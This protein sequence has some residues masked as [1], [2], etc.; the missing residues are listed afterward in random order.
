MTAYVLV[1]LG[2][3][4]AIIGVMIV[5]FLRADSRIDKLDAKFESKIDKVDAKFDVM[6]R[7]VVDVKISVARIEGYLQARDGFAPSAGDRPVSRPDVDQPPSGYRQT[8]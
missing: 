3:G 8:G 2:T 7:D 1:D 5:L 4:M 6:A